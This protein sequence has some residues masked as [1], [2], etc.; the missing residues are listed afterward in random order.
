MR[1]KKKLKTLKSSYTRKFVGKKQITYASLYSTLYVNH[2]N[3][4]T[5]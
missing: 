1:V 2:R 4:Y 3:N 5:N